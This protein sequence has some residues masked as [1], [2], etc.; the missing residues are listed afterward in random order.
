MRTMLRMMGCISVVLLLTTG[1][2]LS[3]SGR[4]SGGA[5]KKE[6]MKISGWIG[7]TVQ[8]V[9]EKV[10]RK[11]K[12]DSEEGAYVNEVFEDSPADSAGIQE[13]DVIIEFNEKKIFDSDDLVKVVHRTLP[14]TKVSLVIVREGEKKTLHLTVGKKKES[15]H[16]IFG[17][18]PNIPDVHVFA[19]NR[20]LGLQLLALNEQLGE[21]FG[22]PNNEGVLV[23]EVEHK[24]YC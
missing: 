17:G 10:V 20:I 1:T 7:V 9:N 5:Q 18:M 13:C 14:E 12:L 2:M 8:D 3:A 21:Y 4:L 6:K 11:A 23:E 15:Q 24:R 16:C 19:G 22:T